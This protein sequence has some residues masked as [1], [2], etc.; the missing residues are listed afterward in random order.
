MLLGVLKAKNKLLYQGVDLVG[1]DVSKIEL[2]SLA[3]ARG[4]LVGEG[5]CL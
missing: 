1:S 4:C 3:G 2:L 5:S